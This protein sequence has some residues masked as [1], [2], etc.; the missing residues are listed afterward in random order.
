MVDQ[1]QID[2]L[3]CM[4]MADAYGDFK[5]MKQSFDNMYRVQHTLGQYSKINTTQGTGFY[6]GIRDIDSDMN[7]LGIEL[8]QLLK[9][10]CPMVNP[11]ST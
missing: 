10:V 6:K 5:D 2:R 11:S 7:D 3:V 8:Q 4:W 1:D 9:R